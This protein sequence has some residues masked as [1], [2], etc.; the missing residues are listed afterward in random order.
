M[1]DERAEL[2]AIGDRLSALE[3]ERA[4]LERLLATRREAVAALARI[5]EELRRGL[6]PRVARWLLALVLVLLLGGV[7]GALYL[8]AVVEGRVRR[9][10]FAGGRDT[11]V[12]HLLITSEPA[13]ASVSIDGRAA[14]VT[15]LLTPASPVDR[16]H[17]VRIE[18]AGHLALERE[19]TVTRSAGAHLHARLERR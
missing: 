6:L 13:G 12:P 15:P 18:A 9:E 8:D 16:R 10:P 7:A 3:R 14:G 2:A 17:S 4:E 19:L 11:L 1:P 5:V